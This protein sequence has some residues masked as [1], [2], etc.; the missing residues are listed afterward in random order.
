MPDVQDNTAAQAAETEQAAQ[1]VDQNTQSPAES[2]ATDGAAVVDTAPD[3]QAPATDA[4]VADA[5]DAA[6][7]DENGQAEVVHPAVGEM[8]ALRASI[9]NELTSILTG[10]RTRVHNGEAHL[11]SLIERL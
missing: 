5:A 10:I 1:A 7:A 2:P 3:A 9:K 8:N 4:D 11:V 6:K